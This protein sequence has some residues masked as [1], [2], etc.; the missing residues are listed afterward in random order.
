MLFVL[1][2]DS[3][4]YDTRL[5]WV[6]DT[7]GSKMLNGTIV[8]IGDSAAP[9]SLPL[10]VRETQCPTHSHEEGACCKY[11]EAVIEAGRRMQL[12]PSLAWAYFIDDDV[13][14]R[15]QAVAR[16]LGDQQGASA[17]SDAPNGV[18]RGYFMCGSA[19]EEG[20]VC[21]EGLCGGGGYAADRRAIAAMLSDGPAVFLQKQMDNCKKCNRWA[22][23]AV[24]QFAADKNITKRDLPG[25]YGWTMKKAEFD[26]S[27]ERGSPEPLMYHY[28]QSEQQMSFLHSLF[29][30]TRSGD[31]ASRQEAEERA[32]ARLVSRVVARV[33][34][35][36]LGRLLGRW[37]AS[38]GCASFHGETICRHGPEALLST[39]WLSAANSSASAQAA[40]DVAAQA[41]AQAASLVGGNSSGPSAPAVAQ[42]A[43]DVTAQ[44]AADGAAK[45]ASTVGGARGHSV[46]ESAGP[47]PPPAPGAALAEMLVRLAPTTDAPTVS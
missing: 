29:E 18:V 33:V 17:P 1:Y 16:A 47:A 22:D 26:K 41:A 6:M 42:A 37:D 28:I 44:A 4:F 31:E 30:P 34:S 5:R 10:P 23:L 39:P 46:P 21:T 25:A 13:Y 43:A 15:P 20:P 38:S 3:N 32:G 35:R 40:A 36:V 14:A 45:T 9:E 7:W 8:A 11:G 27:L 19:T 24:S 2:S 12:D